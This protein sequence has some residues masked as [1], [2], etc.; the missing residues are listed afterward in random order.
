MNK[1]VI[2]YGIRGEG[3]REIEYYLSNDYEIIGYSDSDVQYYTCH[4][5]NYKCFFIPEKL[6]EQDFDYIIIT[7]KDL[8][9]SNEI[10]QQI[11]ARG[12]G[13]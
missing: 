12:G 10:R 8:K 4:Y 5:I 3:R 11:I 13:K 1:K 2:L 9:I 6:A 7:V